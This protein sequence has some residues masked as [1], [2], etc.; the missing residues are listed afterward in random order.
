VDNTIRIHPRSTKF[1]A[2]SLWLAKLR[3]LAIVGRQA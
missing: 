3:T 2:M 1:N